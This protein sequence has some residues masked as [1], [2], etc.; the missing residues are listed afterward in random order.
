MTRPPP[1][2]RGLLFRTPKKRNPNLSPIRKTK[3]GFLSFGPSGENRTHGLLNPIQARY[4][5]CATPGYAQSSYRSQLF[6]YTGWHLFCQAFFKLILIYLFVCSPR[7]QQ[8]LL[9][10]RSGPRRPAMPGH[11]QKR[12]RQWLLHR[13]PIES[14][15]PP[16]VEAPE[17]GK[18][19]LYSPIAPPSRD[20]PAGCFYESGPM[21]PVPAEAPAPVPPAKPLE[22]AHYTLA[23]AGRKAPGPPDRTQAPGPSAA[24]ARQL[25][26]SSQSRPQTE[27]GR[28]S[29][30][31]GLP[32][33][34]RPG[35]SRG[36]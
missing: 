22:P 18:R 35:I 5:N 13:P 8:A 9:R 21:P 12:W 24:V 11:K 17:P 3:F 10:I 30:P 31:A 33:S 2:I 32:S 15:Y 6:Y 16:P 1:A 26:P 34:F 19:Q 7:R 25:R 36:G 28:P 27:A 23:H 20:L 4:Q 14:A 29:I